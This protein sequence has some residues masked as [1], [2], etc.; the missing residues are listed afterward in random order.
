MVFDPDIP[1]PRDNLSVSQADL[2]ENFSEL[3]T[4]F[5]VN[6]VPFNDP[7]ANK[8]KHNFVTLVEQSEDP[9][10]KSDE[11]L[12]YSKDDAG[13]C[14]IYARP[15]ANGNPFQITKDG[16]LFLGIT[17]IV[18]VNFERVAPFIKGSSLGVASIAQPVTGTFVITFTAD[19]T[20]ALNGSNDYF[21][22]VSGF[23]NQNVNPVIAEVTNA[24]NYND[25]VKTT[26]IS[27]SFRNQNGG[28]VSGLTRAS[29][30]CWR[31]Q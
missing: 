24:V 21:W 23:D 9:E 25:V 22:T 29:V 3:N 15:E 11:Y 8:G 28:P 5:G 17:P 12:L 19:V 30:M 6:H 7:G 14:E 27:V 18:A 26:S 10:S 20:T 4:Q 16:N 1:Q 13:D 31:F 2:L